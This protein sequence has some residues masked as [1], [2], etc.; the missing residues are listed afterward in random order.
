MS[1]T[2]LLRPRAPAAIAAPE[3]APE[4]EAGPPPPADPDD[5]GALYAEMLAHPSAASVE[6]RMDELT[7]AQRA[8]LADVILARADLPRPLPA[9]WAW[10]AIRSRL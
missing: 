6:R 10:L 9:W 4:P 1:K 5:P 7:R 8:A 2:R 3:G